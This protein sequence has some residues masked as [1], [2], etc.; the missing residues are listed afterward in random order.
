M[1]SKALILIGSPCPQM[2]SFSSSFSWFILLLEFNWFYKSQALWY[3][4]GG[5]SAIYLVA[6]ALLLAFRSPSVIPVT[7]LNVVR[8]FRLVT[9]ILLVGIVA[10][11]Q[12][13]PIRCRPVDEER[14]PLL[15]D[16]RTRN[17][18]DAY[19]YGTISRSPV[20]HPQGRDDQGGLGYFT[21][22]ITVCAIQSHGLEK[23]KAD[24]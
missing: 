6:E 23:K 14:V 1:L 15:R 20:R 7:I 19:P 13:I 18:D 21:R 24:S 9:L 11:S 3:P 17:P 12:A 10:I 16:D 5:C 2:Y 4:L 8:I 22:R